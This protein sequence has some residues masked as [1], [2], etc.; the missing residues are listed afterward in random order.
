MKIKLEL[1]VGPETGTLVAALENIIKNLSGIDN[2]VMAMYRSVAER[3]RDDINFQIQ[4]KTE[5]Y[6]KLARLRAACEK[7]IGGES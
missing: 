1:E 7:V 2:G 6:E 4:A 5:E 3:L